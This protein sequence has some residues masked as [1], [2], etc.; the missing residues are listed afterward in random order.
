M[1]NTFLFLTLLLLSL[2]SISQNIN[3]GDSFPQVENLIK[4]KIQEANRRDSNGY[5]QPKI[6]Y[7]IKLNDKGEKVI[8]TYQNDQIYLDLNLK[9]NIITKYVFEYEN[10]SII[11]TLFTSIPIENLQTSFNNKY[12][13]REI[14]QRYFSEDYKYYRTITVDEG[15]ST[16]VYKM[17]EKENNWDDLNTI[18]QNKQR[19][20]VGN[21]KNRG[22]R[23]I[24]RKSLLFDYFQVDDYIDNYSNDMKKQLMPLI[25]KLFKDDL[26]KSEVYKQTKQFKR[27]TEDYTIRFY[28]ASNS[29]YS[30]HSIVR[31]SLND[32]Y[33]P[34][35]LSGLRFKI[36]PITED[37]EGREY[38]LNREFFIDF[39]VN[40]LRGSVEIKSRKGKS[41]ETL[42]ETKLLDEHRELIEQKIKDL[43]TGKYTVIY[44][45]GKINGIDATKI[46][47]YKK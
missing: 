41:F 17:Y 13:Q 45:F 20:Y 19:E 39:Q 22:N 2:P 23:R 37:F 34:S 7:E 8:Y 47:T 12:S 46:L 15:F 24:K 35:F 16:V 40:L 32:K 11:K 44:Q 6:T 27:L 1:K 29:K 36:Q 4:F 25:V 21:S 31:D 43:K 26:E 3:I 9:S 18:V 5:K 38:K 28:S 30:R 42:T 33:L 14:G 10:L